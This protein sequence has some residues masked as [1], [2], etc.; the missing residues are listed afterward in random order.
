MHNALRLRPS[1]LLFG[2]SSIHALLP[3]TLTAQ[4]ESLL[5]NGKIADAQALLDKAETQGGQLEVL[6]YLHQC[7]AFKLFGQ[8]RFRDAT[9][10]FV[11]GASDPRILI[12][13]FEELRPALCEETSSPE[14]TQTDAD[15]TRSDSMEIEVYAGVQKYMPSETSVDDIIRNYSPYL[16]PQVLSETDAADNVQYASTSSIPSSSVSGTRTHPATVAMRDI[17]GTQAREMVEAA[18]SALLVE[19]AEFWARDIVEVTATA[20][21]LH[22]AHSGDVPSPLSSF[23][24][25]LQSVPPRPPSR[26]PSRPTSS[27]LH[28]PPSE[29]SASL[30]PSARSAAHALQQPTMTI[31]PRILARVLETLNLWGPLIELWRTVGDVGRLINVLA[32]L[33]E[34][35]YHDSSVSDPLGQM[36]AILS[37]LQ[38]PERMVT[39]VVTDPAIGE[40][41][42]QSLIRKWGVWLAAR[43]VERGLSLL[44]SGLPTR[45]QRPTVVGGRTKDK[46]LG[47]EQEKTDELAV[48]AELRKT[49]TTAAKKYL[50]WLI[51]GR[52]RE[53]SLLQCQLVESCVEDL[54]ECLK[55]DTIA[56]LWRAKCVSYTSTTPTTSAPLSRVSSSDSGSQ[57]PWAT[58]TPP[59]R[60]PFLSYFVSTT[61]DS[62]S[63]R[64]R[65]KALLA[66]QA[67]LVSSEAE[68]EALAKRVQERI[69]EGGWEKVLGLEVAVLHSKLSEPSVVLRT[70]HSLRDSV[71]AEAYASSAGV[72]GVISPRAGA[73][74]AEGCELAD[75]AKW[76]VK[77]V[78]DRNLAVKRAK[79]ANLG[80]QPPSEM[81]KI[82][83][84]VYTEDGDIQQVSRLLSSQAHSLDIP[85]IVSLVPESWPLHSI[86]SFLARSLRRSVHIKHE[87][88]IVKEICAG[89]NLEVLQ[90]SYFI[91]QQEGATIEEAVEDSEDGGS[92]EHL[93]EKGEYVEKVAMH[94]G[95]GDV[96]VV[97]VEADG[98]G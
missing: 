9:Q 92:G 16:R 45:A 88:Q 50:E 89:Q 85:D 46:D 60:P 32:G 8:T 5:E 73:S 83:L 97:D 95:Q 39:D 30:S 24:P 79:S 27:Q 11:K 67:T 63:K 29:T 14:P 61:P 23:R 87:G 66:L 3:S 91:L 4:V 15:S 37:S 20:L 53:N 74:A 49:G 57:L 21:A 70:L 2:Q 25:P 59:P 71:T 41:E 1:V 93:D 10:H 80:G 44:M 62:R 78:E 65:I 51:V 22:Y 81:L 64:A 6:Q 58:N 52:G 7:T 34:G 38:Q 77:A 72:Y 84:Q 31:R 36:F 35:T 55:D 13:Y 40:A 19:Q 82:L 48:L 43:D 75:W 69:V 47:K 28:L 86:S 96:H 18:L 98:G 94:L 33:V 42:R 12:S 90:R 26:P 76:F 54:F 17:L 56:K 68:G